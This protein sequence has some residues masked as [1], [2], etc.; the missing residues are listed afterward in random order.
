MCVH[1]LCNRPRTLHGV[2]ANEPLS[3][4]PL[5]R[6]LNILNIYRGTVIKYTHFTLP[7]CQN[8]TN[9]GVH[10]LHKDTQ[11]DTD[12]NTQRRQLH[13]LLTE[14]RVPRVVMYEM[15]L[16]A[17]RLFL[18][19]YLSVAC[20]HFLGVLL[21]WYN[22]YTQIACIDVAF[23]QII[24]GLFFLCVCVFMWCWL[25]MRVQCLWAIKTACMLFCCRTQIYTTYAQRAY[26]KRERAQK[27][28]TQRA[29]VMLNIRI[30]C[31]RNHAVI[32]RQALH[33]KI[34][35]ARRCAR[36]VHSVKPQHFHSSTKCMCV[37][38]VCG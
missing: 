8:Q 2:H 34:S 38:R 3:S 23:I 30:C 35:R 16:D 6:H 27:K 37:F 22:T 13:A 26:N 33:G 15:C 11:T 1:Y 19:L 28:N 18:S 12:T 7:S 20:G 36:R 31:A 5:V 14:Y 25:R 24:N 9:R 32:F 17:R 10:R 4:S 21:I 29:I